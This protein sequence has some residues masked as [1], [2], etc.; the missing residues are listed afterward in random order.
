MDR[1]IKSLKHELDSV[2][3]II[4]NYKNFGVSR[5][6]IQEKYLPQLDFLQRAWSIVSHPKRTNEWKFKKLNELNFTTNYLFNELIEPSLNKM[7]KM[8]LP[9]METESLPQPEIQRMI[10]LNRDEE[11]LKPLMVPEKAQEKME[12]DLPKM[13][14]P[15]LLEN[16]PE[17][18]MLSKDLSEKQVMA[19]IR[20]LTK[21]I[22]STKK[23]LKNLEKKQ[24][25]KQQQKNISNAKK[26]KYQRKFNNHLRDSN[27]DRAETY[28]RLLGNPKNLRM[29][30]LSQ[31]ME[32]LRRERRRVLETILPQDMPELRR[33]NSTRIE[34]KL[35]NLPS[36]LAPINITSIETVE[37][38][39]KKV[40]S[41]IVPEVNR[42]N[43]EELR[44]RR[45]NASTMFA[46]LNAT[47][48]R[49][50]R[51]KKKPKKSAET[52]QK[53][54]SALLEALA[55]R[56]RGFVSRSEESESEESESE[57]SESEE[58]ESEESRSDESKIEAAPK[59]PEIKT[60]E[61]EI[62]RLR[63]SRR[64][65][66]S[67]LFAGLRGQR[68]KLKT[69]KGK[70]KANNPKVKDHNIESTQVI[71][72]KIESMLGNMSQSE[73]D[74]DSGSW[75]GGAY[76]KIINP[77]NNKEYSIFSSQGKKLL[78]LYVSELS[79]L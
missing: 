54:N 36:E 66:A 77:F 24:I 79:K 67:T 3:L 48:N 69:R 8:S 18:P 10:S 75:E 42:S 30:L 49:L 56:R 51:H 59:I 39:P 50:R 17:V 44:E 45:R 78:K 72:P 21:N 7:K 31:Q 43:S 68:G 32:Q 26:I 16:I 5:E 64:R 60:S 22:E 4:D 55:Q 46:Q 1:I 35:S 20:K 33:G 9:K 63:E 29:R 28:L 58:S 53:S 41:P 38:K 14:P 12:F 23:H 15:S 6:I 19:K 34:P 73:S 57:E 61:S 47:K 40:A 62:E 65:N 27:Y 13:E 11:L 70:K 76:Y 71:N 74:S 2:Q 52:R 37:S 25:K